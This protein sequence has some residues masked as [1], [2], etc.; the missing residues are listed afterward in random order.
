M[1]RA[2]Y[3]WCS[4]PP[5]A[6]WAT[7]VCMNRW[8]RWNAPWR[9]AR[10]NAVS[11]TSSIGEEKSFSSSSCQSS[12]STKAI[13]FLC[14]LRRDF[15]YAIS[16]PSWASSSSSTKPSSPSSSAPPSSSSLPTSAAASSSSSSSSSSASL[17]ALASFAARPTTWA[18]RDWGRLVA[19]SW[20]RAESPRQESL[21]ARWLSKC[22]S[23]LNQSWKTASMLPV[24]WS[25]ARV[26]A[27]L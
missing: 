2:W 7:Q 21:R 17:R 16:S 25:C 5:G 8:S 15:M 4:S 3:A 12:A 6:S 10:K 13:I 19:G 22:S 27:G 24:P 18:A 9:Q 14:S 1:V 26:S 11:S 20:R 23:S